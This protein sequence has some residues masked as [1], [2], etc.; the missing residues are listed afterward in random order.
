MH[1]PVSPE[2]LQVAHLKA[3]R[4]GLV[5]HLRYH[6]QRNNFPGIILALFTTSS[7]LL[8]IS[9]LKEYSLPQHVI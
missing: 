6:S 3:A 4:H 7:K 5:Y 1:F 9:F 8:L 2:E